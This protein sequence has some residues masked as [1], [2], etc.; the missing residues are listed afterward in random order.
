MVNSVNLQILHKFTNVF[1]FFIKILITKCKEFCPSSQYY[2]SSVITVGK[3]KVFF[4][5]V[6]H[7]FMLPSF[8]LF[9]I[10]THDLTEAELKRV[11]SITTG[12]PLSSTG[13]RSSCS[14]FSSDHSGGS[15]GENSCCL[16]DLKF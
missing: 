1:F 3:D 9:H 10:G 11:E 7:C 14:L 4:I 13:Y 15:E 5:F 2:M 16:L 12:A 6:S 8:I